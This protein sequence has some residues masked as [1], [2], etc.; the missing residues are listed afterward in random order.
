MKRIKPI[1]TRTASELA[2]ALGLSKAAGVEFEV[3]STLNTKIIQVVEKRGLTHAEVAKLVGMSRPRLTALLNRNSA[4]VSTD[5][6]LRILSALGVS[7][8]I[9][10][11][12]AA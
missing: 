10:F 12:R 11:G 2:E 7:A 1:V 6:L 8:K 3:R 5:L 4:H 9:T